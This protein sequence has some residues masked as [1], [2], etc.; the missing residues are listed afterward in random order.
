MHQLGDNRPIEP[1]TGKHEHKGCKKA[2]FEGMNHHILLYNLK[3][4][5]NIE[6]QMMRH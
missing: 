1:R 6:E 2:S 5:E 3:P 4:C